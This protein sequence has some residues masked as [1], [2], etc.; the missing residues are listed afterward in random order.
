ML[1]ILNDNGNVDFREP[2]GARQ[3]ALCLGIPSYQVSFYT[4]PPFVAAEGG[5]QLLKW[6]AEHA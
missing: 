3:F 5:K 4:Y 6:L 2:V 1:V